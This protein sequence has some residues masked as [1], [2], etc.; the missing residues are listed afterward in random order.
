M[1][2]PCRDG[3]LRPVAQF[4]DMQFGLIQATAAVLCTV[5]CVV[6]Q[7]LDEGHLESDL[8]REMATDLQR[9]PLRLFA[10]LVGTSC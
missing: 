5:I 9:S 2:I 6:V 8:V 7:G 4:E 1:M 10:A 3:L